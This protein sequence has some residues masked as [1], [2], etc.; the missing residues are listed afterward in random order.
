MA[1]A[2]IKVPEGLWYAVERKVRK[3][4]GNPIVWSGGPRMIEK[5]HLNC[6]GIRYTK[7][8]E[9]E[10][11]NNCLLVCPEGQRNLKTRL[12]KLIEEAAI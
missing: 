6:I 11:Y 4:F 8:V 7:E 1:Q 10:S 3:E 5:G 9:G 12:N 2:T